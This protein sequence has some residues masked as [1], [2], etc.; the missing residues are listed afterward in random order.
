MARRA[1]SGCPAFACEAGIDARPLP[2]L[3]LDLSPARTPR[4]CL[5]SILATIHCPAAPNIYYGYVFPH[6]SHSR[7]LKC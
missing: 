2:S 1:V 3:I 4:Y 6:E 5:G 7:G